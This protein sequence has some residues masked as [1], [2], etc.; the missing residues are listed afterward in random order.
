MDKGR[1]D[2]I[3]VINQGLHYKKKQ[4][5]LNDIDA[6]KPALLSAMNRGARVIWQEKNAAHFNTTDG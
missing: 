2:D 6:I 1:K 5:L 3:V 4:E